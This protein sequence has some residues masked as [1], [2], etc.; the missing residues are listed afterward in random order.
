MLHLFI[1]VME[2]DFV[3]TK[4]YGIYDSPS[5]RSLATPKIWFLFMGTSSGRVISS[6]RL[7]NFFTMTM[8]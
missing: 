1:S 6:G 7:Y 8:V 3:F 4:L 5:L 2:L